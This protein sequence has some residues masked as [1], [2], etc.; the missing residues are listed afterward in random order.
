VLESK[1]CSHIDLL[2]SFSLFSPS[3]MPALLINI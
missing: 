2:I 3:K 1:D